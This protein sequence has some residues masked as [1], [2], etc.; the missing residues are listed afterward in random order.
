MAKIRLYR[1]KNKQQNLFFRSLI[2]ISELRSKILTFG[3]TQINLFFRSLIR[4]FV[5]EEYTYYG[6]YQSNIILSS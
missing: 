4:I 5:I 3:K 1:Q 2:R 6:I